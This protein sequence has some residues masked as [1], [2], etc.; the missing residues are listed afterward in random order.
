MS[1]ILQELQDSQIELESIKQ[2][3]NILKLEITEYETRINNLQQENEKLTNK[4][5]ILLQ[6][7]QLEQQNILYSRS[8]SDEMELI[9]SHNADLTVQISEYQNL[10]KRLTSQY[11][12]IQTENEK[13]KLAL[14]QMCEQQPQKHKI[15]NN[16]ILKL[17]NKIKTLQ[18]ECDTLRENINETNECNT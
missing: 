12:T 7:I 16:E 3:N 1:L 2:E 10:T 5:N 15:H 9:N 8:L 4:N 18:N 6:S 14:Q 13:Y 11:K 17:Q